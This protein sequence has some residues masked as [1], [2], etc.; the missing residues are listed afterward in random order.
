MIAEVRSL[1]SEPTPNDGVDLGGVALRARAHCIRMAALGGCFLG[2]ALSSV[3][4][5]TY[6]YFRVL[7]VSPDSPVSSDRDYLLLSKGHAVPAL[8]GVLA[9]RGFIDPKR[10]DHHLDVRDSIYWHPN[11]SV[12]GVD[13]HTGSLGHALG[14]ALGIALDLRL[15]ASSRRAFV[16]LG[17]G[18]LNE[19]S[20]WEAALVAGAQKLGNLVA[21]VDR[22]DLQANIATESLVPLESIGDKFRHFGWRVAEADGHSF[23]DLR[24]G[25]DSLFA[26]ASSPGVLIARTTRGKGLPSI[27]NRVDKWFVSTTEAERDAFL[28]ELEGALGAR[29]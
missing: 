21:V 29:S 14:V 2:A 9:E 16:V 24:R 4:L 6:L 13:F 7:H 27:E 17:D 5:L 10:L 3:D 1:D 28:S 15:S 19:G 12:P 22:N 25:F 18:E 20:V 26:D 23:A 11:R 8:Y